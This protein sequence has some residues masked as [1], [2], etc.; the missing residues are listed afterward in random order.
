MK[1]MERRFRL[2]RDRFP[3]NTQEILQERKANPPG[4]VMAV[5][6]WSTTGF[7]SCFVSGRSL[8]CSG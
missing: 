2:S 4:N 6:Y 3:C 5:L 7:V 8:A 1:E